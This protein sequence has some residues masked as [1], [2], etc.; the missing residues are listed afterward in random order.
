MQQIVI[1]PE[2]FPGSQVQTDAV[3]LDLIKRSFNTVY[4]GS[5]TCAMGKAGDKNAVV[6]SHA[7]VMGVNSLRVVD[8]PG[9]PLL[10]AWAS[11]GYL[12]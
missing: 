11:H 8:A 3:S 2:Y 10:K 4:H 5:A 7:K 6:D 9:F 12:L 1:G